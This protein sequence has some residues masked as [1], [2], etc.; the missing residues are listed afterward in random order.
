MSGD[1]YISDYKLDEIRKEYGEKII[2]FSNVQKKIQKWYSEFGL[3]YPASSVNNYR[4]SWFHYRK[5]WTERS[6]YEVICQVATLDE[7]LQRAEKDAV[8]NFFQILSQELEYWYAIENQ[9]MSKEILNRVRQEADSAYMRSGKEDQ[10]NGLWLLGLWNAYG[11]KEQE[12]SFALIYAAQTYLLSSKDMK[13]QIQRLLHQIK[14]TTIKIRFEASDI[15]RLEYPGE[16][17]NRYQECYD[18]VRSFFTKEENKGFFFLLGMT[19]IVK[20]NEE[21]YV[22]EKE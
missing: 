20:I 6:Y 4:D 10:S 17:V 11:G 22:M 8:V 19:N 16:Y 3:P 1:N 18:A 5:I 15:R 7:H 2:S 14:N 13:K 12:A 21:S 9:D